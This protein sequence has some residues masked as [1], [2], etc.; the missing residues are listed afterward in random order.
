M[1][2]WY[3]K[4]ALKKAVF[5]KLFVTLL[6]MGIASIEIKTKSKIFKIKFWTFT[7]RKIVSQSKVCLL[8][9]QKNAKMFH[10]VV[11]V[12]AVVYCST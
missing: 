1:L 9:N 12:V 7:K 10:C 5:Q 2:F 4:V 11:I 6:L 3:Q 8:A